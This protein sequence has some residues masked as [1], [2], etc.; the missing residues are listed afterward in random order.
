MPCTN[1]H[2]TASVSPHKSYALQGK[3][4]L[5][6]NCLRQRPGLRHS[7]FSTSATSCWLKDIR[8]MKPLGFYFLL[9]PCSR[10]GAL[11]V[12]FSHRHLSLSTLTTQWRMKNLFSPPMG[13]RRPTCALAVEAARSSPFRPPRMGKGRSHVCA[14]HA[15]LFQRSRRTMP[16]TPGRNTSQTSLSTAWLEQSR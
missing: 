14:A 5:C 7:I 9:L 8:E 13:A 15:A 3:N 16:V 2:H 11:G 12:S 10:T 4:Q 6:D 1:T